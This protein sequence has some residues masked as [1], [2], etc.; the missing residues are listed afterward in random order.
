[1]KFMRA[2]QTQD[3]KPKQIIRLFSRIKSANLMELPEKEFKKFAGEIESSQLFKKLKDDRIIKLEKLSS[4]NSPLCFYEL[5]EEIFSDRSLLDVESFL[6]GKENVIRIIRRLG[7]DKFKRYFLS[8]DS[9][10]DSEIAGKCDLS[11]KEIYKIKK[12]VDELLIRNESQIQSPAENKINEIYYNKI[13]SIIKEDGKF[14][15]G[16]LNFRLYRGTYIVDYAKIGQLKKQNYFTN[17]EIGELRKLLQ[18]IEL[19]NGRKLAI[20]RILESII[21][22]Q[23]NYLK[24][25]DLLDLT[26]LTQHEL[27]RRTGISTSHICRVIRCK[28]IETPRGEEEPLKFFFPSKKLIIKNYIKNVFGDK[29]KNINSDQEL[30]IKIEKELKLP[31][32]RRSVTLYRNELQDREGDIKND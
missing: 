32:S 27:S 20:H 22:Y 7:V 16:Y 29:S 8:E 3:R 19:I 21:K 17:T 1:M 9:V 2:R 6:N 28:S 4:V 18:N 31:T 25:G 11:I 30:K 10:S 13:A 5:K 26:P 24:S 12:L 15:I 23:K 14:T